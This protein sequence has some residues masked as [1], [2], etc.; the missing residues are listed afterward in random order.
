MVDL[1]GKS[2]PLTGGFQRREEQVLQIKW[3]DATFN[4]DDFHLGMFVPNTK[5]K[6][7]EMIGNVFIRKIVC[8]EIFKNPNVIFNQLEI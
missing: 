1:T 4:R 6:R 8:Q 3:D 2:K 7:K 5:Q